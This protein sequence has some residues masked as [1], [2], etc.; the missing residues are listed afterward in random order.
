MFGAQVIRA[1]ESYLGLPSLVGKSKINTF[2]QLKQRVENKVSGWK[3]KLLSSAGKEVLI[4]AV[5]QAVP[6]YTMSCFKLPNKLCDE[7]TAQ[8]LVRKGLR[9]QVGNGENIRIWRDKWLPT[10]KTYK[11]VTPEKSNTRLTM[12]CDLIDNES[13]EWKVD[14][15]RQNFLAQDVDAILSIPLSVNGASDKIVWAENRNG[16][17]SVRS[18]YKAQKWSDL[19]PGMVERTVMICWGIW[20]DW[21]EICHGG[22]GRPGRA[23]VRSALMLLEEY[24]S[25]NESSEAV[26]ESTP[27]TVKWS[28]P[29]QGWYK[30]NVDGAVFTKRKQTGIRVIIRDDTGAMVAAISKKMAVPFGALEMEAKAMETGVRFAAEV[31]VRDAIFEGDS[32]SVYNAVHGSGSASTAIQNIVTG[33][34][35]QAQGFRMFV[36]SHVK[37]QGNAPAHAL[38]QYAGQLEDYVTWLEECPS[39]IESMCAQDVRG[40]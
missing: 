4:K 7:L 13:K 25:V 35:R 17:F 30:V 5:A 26:Q 12:V 19:L 33:I 37:R 6:S 16:R 23:V 3:E 20:K 15:V 14:V 8:A 31:G 29:P 22:K 24:Q 40:F 34:L 32:L 39:H 27:M 11:V 28:L 1:H 10:P 18:A 2:A 9:W 36:L 38:A 21:N